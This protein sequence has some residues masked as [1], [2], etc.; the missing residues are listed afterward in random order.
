MLIISEK[1]VTETKEASNPQRFSLLPVP[2]D[3]GKHKVCLLCTECGGKL[4]GVFAMTHFLAVS[5][6]L[7]ECYATKTAS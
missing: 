4:Q 1:C 5:S 7:G 3:Q 6:H 2:N